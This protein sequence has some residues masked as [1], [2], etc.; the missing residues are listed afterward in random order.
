VVLPLSAWQPCDTPPGEQ[1]ELMRRNWM[2]REMSLKLVF[3]KFNHLVVTYI[4]GYNIQGCLILISY[5]R[6]AHCF[7][8]QIR[9]NIVVIADQSYEKSE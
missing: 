3:E 6:Q 1:L 2:K 9:H 4:A 8:F 7:N 5:Y